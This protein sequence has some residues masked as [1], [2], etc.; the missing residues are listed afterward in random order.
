[1]EVIQKRKD[2]KIT[3]YFVWG[4]YEKLF[5]SEYV[6][7]VSWEAFLFKFLLI[8]GLVWL[9]MMLI[10]YTASNNV[11]EALES[12][13]V[14]Q[15]PKIT[16]LQIKIRE[17]N[18]NSIDPVLLEPTIE[19]VK[20]EY[21]KFME[22]WEKDHKQIYSEQ[23]FNDKLIN[24]VTKWEGAFQA[25]AFCDDYYKT[26]TKLIRKS[27]SDCGKWTIGFWTNSFL[28]EHITYQE[29]ITRR[30]RAIISRK[31]GIK[32]TCLSDNARIIAIDFIYQY[33]SK[34]ANKMRH[35]ANT[36][37]ESL[38]IGYIVNHRDYYKRKKQTGMVKREQAR[39]NLYYKQGTND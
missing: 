22:Q 34:Y 35:F 21:E 23:E 24:F 6:K 29:A 27:P 2:K 3:T 38:I 19:P 13:K 16:K 4:D 11:V 18:S 32:S 14:I 20:T 17:Y 25:K 10:G 12:P 8:M 31:E 33:S 7:P 37:Q 39:I 15:W 9:V 36:C 28:G 1:M 30:D 26:E 5:R